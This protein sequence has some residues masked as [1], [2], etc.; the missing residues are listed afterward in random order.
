MKVDFCFIMLSL[1]AGFQIYAQDVYGKKVVTL[2]HGSFNWEMKRPSQGEILRSGQRTSEFQFNE[3]VFSFQETFFDSDVEQVGFFGYNAK[4]NNIFSIGIYNVD[5]GPHILRGTL[6]KM[7][8]GYLVRFFE[9]EKQVVLR[10]MS[11]MHHFWEYYSK[12]GDQWIKDDLRIDFYRK[13][14]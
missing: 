7:T 1:I 6:Q 3:T 5:M 10:V 12:T 9:G 14:E 2:L 11:N 8:N 4:E 13:P